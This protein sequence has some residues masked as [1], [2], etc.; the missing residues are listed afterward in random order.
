MNIHLNRAHL[1]MQ[2]HRFDLAE[3]QLRLALAEGSETATA[4]AF[5]SLCLIESGKIEDAIREAQQ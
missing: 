1:L 5:L 2:Q 4:H 3:E